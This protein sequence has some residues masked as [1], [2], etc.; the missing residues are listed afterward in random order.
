MH[1]RDTAN[2][3]NAHLLLY[4]GSQDRG[5]D[6]ICT[7]E[8]DKSTWLQAREILAHVSFREGAHTNTIA[9]DSGVSYDASGNDML[10]LIPAL[11]MAGARSACLT[12]WAVDA[13]VADD[14]TA[15]F[16]HAWEIA[17]EE[18]QLREGAADLVNLAPCARTA[19]LSLMGFS[20]TDRAT[21]MRKWAPYIYHGFSELQDQRG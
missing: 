2:P 12:L 11:F 8:P 18:A 6:A 10:G 16:V 3:M 7:G 17:R 14:W 1:N 21:R 20:S 15:Q 9:C 19:S 4:T 5:D 13:S